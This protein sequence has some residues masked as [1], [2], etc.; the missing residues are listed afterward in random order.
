[1]YAVH[2]NG[3]TMLLF[4]SVMAKS[5]KARSAPQYVRLAWKREYNAPFSEAE[6]AESINART[7]ASRL[8]RFPKVVIMKKRSCLCVVYMIG[9]RTTGGSNSRMEILNY[10]IYVDVV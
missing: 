2:V 5:F 9:S 6:M 1:M 4:E 8:E 10:K 3:N 7:S